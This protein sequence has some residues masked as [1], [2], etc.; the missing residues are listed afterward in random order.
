MRRSP[1][2][3]SD[4]V[5]GTG[6]RFAARIGRLG[7]ESA[8]EVLARAKA[9]EAQG[10]SVVHLEIGEPDFDTPENVIDAAVGALRSGW[11]HYTP[12]AGIPE[13][14][15]AIAKYTAATRK[16]DVS[17][18]NV[19]VFPGAKPTMSYLILAL[20]DPG[21]EVIY[22]NPGFPIYESMIEFAGGKAVP[23][24]LLED[25]DFGFDASTVEK[26]I[27][28]KT[29]LLILNSPGN[30]TSGVLS[31]KL[32]TE[33]A[34]LAKKHDIFVLSDE[35]YSRIVYDGQEVFSIASLPGMAER[36]CILDG[37]SKTYSMTGW[38]L[39]YGVMPKDIAQCLTKL[40]INFTSCTAAFSQKA[41][42]EA[43]TGSQVAV[44]RMVTEFDARRRLIVDGLNRL[45][46]VRCRMPGGAFYAFPNITG[47]GMSSKDISNRLLNEAGVAVLPGT[48]FGKYGEGFIR[49]SFA[50]S[51]TNIREALGRMERFLA[52]I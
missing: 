31:K 34:E 52:K 45:K 24:P 35:I 39:G 37:F 38:R 48:A 22:P 50:T 8:F 43:L 29:K 42:V 17:A 16:I 23:L 33:V 3:S 15:E 6:T 47:T 9:L 27:T 1:T 32:V 41:G 49:L 36:T 11:T 18:D 7:T 21:D 4:I 10:K 26:L 19:V 30:P 44:D 28:P 14:R 51:Q 46:G 40:A 5:S 13:M 2:E 12:A 25:H 20:I